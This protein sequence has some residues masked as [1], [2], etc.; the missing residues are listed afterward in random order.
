MVG[1]EDQFRV[2]FFD[3]DHAIFTQQPA[4]LDRM[5]DDLQLPADRGSTLHTEPLE[6][7]LEY[8]WDGDGNNA[9]VALTV[10]RHLDSASVSSGLVGDNPDTAWIIDYPMLERIHQQVLATCRLVPRAICTRETGSFQAVRPQ[11]L[12]QPLVSDVFSPVL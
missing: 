4:F 7:A 11:P 9:N 10:F 2:M 8:I 6:M 1:I 3:P 5:A 12:P